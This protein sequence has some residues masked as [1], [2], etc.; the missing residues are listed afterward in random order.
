M[1]VE[2]ER[3][4]VQTDGIEL[5]SDQ[6]IT[7]RMSENKTTG[8]MW[9]ADSENSND[10]FSVARDSSINGDNRNGRVGA[11]GQHFWTLVR[12]NAAAAGQSGT[13]RSLHKRSWETTHVDEI[14][15]KV[16]AI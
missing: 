8:Y 10:V 11:P 4:R 13:F 16:T 1:T 14:V 12:N 9:E 2:A 3:Q 7:I 6:Q 5:A 15:I